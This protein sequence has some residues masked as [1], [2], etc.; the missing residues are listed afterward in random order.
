LLALN[1]RIAVIT[2]H[3]LE[4]RLTKQLFKEVTTLDVPKGL[5]FVPENLQPKFSLVNRKPILPNV[6]ELSEN[7]R[8]HSAKLRVIQKIRN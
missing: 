8:A 6:R 5:P 1:G 7:N 4:D 2:F 3:S